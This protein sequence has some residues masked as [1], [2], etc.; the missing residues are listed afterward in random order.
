M[1][2]RTLGLFPGREIGVQF[3]D[4]RRSRN[5]PPKRTSP[6]TRHHSRNSELSEPSTCHSAFTPLTRIHARQQHA[7]RTAHGSY[8]PPPQ[9]APPPW[10]RGQKQ[11]GWASTDRRS[12][13]PRQPNSGSLR[14]SEEL[15]YW[16]GRTPDHV[17]ALGRRLPAGV[18]AGEPAKQVQFY[19]QHFIISSGYAASRLRGT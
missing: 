2:P 16:S 5:P 15:R 3:A 9:S 18:G 13:P 6:T 8:S 11:S 19:F 7:G 4:G 12:T 10:L 1:S 14:P 17:G